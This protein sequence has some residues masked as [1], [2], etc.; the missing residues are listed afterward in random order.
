MKDHASIRNREYI[1]TYEY[2]RNT[3]YLTSEI[4]RYQNINI[5]AVGLEQMMLQLADKHKAKYTHIQIENLGPTYVGEYIVW[6]INPLDQKI[7]DSI[8]I[9]DVNIKES[10]LNVST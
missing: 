4:E 10:I 3:T 1:I 8:H 5:R 9:Q 7:L 6:M 2:T